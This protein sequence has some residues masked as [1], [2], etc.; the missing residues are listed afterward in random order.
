MIDYHLGKAN[1]VVDALNRKS[2]FTL[3]AM[4]AQLSVFDDGSVLAELRARPV[5]LQEICKAKN[6]N[7]ELQA[8]RTNCESGVES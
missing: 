5:F 1:V 4:N 2:L 3:R 7:N 8:K 6:N